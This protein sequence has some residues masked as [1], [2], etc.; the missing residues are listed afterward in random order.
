MVCDTHVHLVSYSYVIACN[1]T[2]SC[3]YSRHVNSMRNT[4]LYIAAAASLRL[5]ITNAARQGF[6]TR[7]LHFHGSGIAGGGGALGA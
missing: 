6:C 5:A 4:V 3:G 2:H 1:A 7:L